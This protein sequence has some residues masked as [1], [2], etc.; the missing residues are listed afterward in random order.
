M[1]DVLVAPRRE[2]RNASN[3]REGRSG[4]G[5]TATARR[6]R[7]NDR[8]R[9]APS[10]GGPSGKRRHRVRQHRKGPGAEEKAKD[11]PE[12][13]KKSP[14]KSPGRASKRGK[15]TEGTDGGEDG[16]KVELAVGAAGK[17][18]ETTRTSSPRRWPPPP[19]SWGIAC[20]P[21]RRTPRPP[22]RSSEP[23]RS[24]EG[25]DHVRR[26]DVAPPPKISRDVR[27][28]A[29]MM[30]A[31]RKAPPAGSARALGGT[32]QRAARRGFA[33]SLGLEGVAQPLHPL[34][35]SLPL[36]G[37]RLEDGPACP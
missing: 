35:Q 13:N 8:H 18:R 31:L 36:D 21:T 25:E 4:R 32:V 24:R 20:C 16:E 7:A 6:R 10:R 15:A 28:I 2:S 9:R 22:T 37:A 11:A 29:T 34:P 14:V 1:H 26:S 30:C 27:A 19:R 3:P 33:G 17:T 23:S 5:P 12:K